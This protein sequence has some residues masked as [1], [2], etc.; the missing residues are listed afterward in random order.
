MRAAVAAAPPR[1]PAWR[2]TAT[3]SPSPPIERGEVRRL[4]A[5]RGTE[6]E[7]ALAGL[8]VE[9][10]GDG[11][12]GARLRHE[13]RPPAHSASR[14][15]RT[16]RRATRPSGSRS[17]GCVATGRRSGELLRAS[18]ASVFA[19]SAVSAGSLPAAI[20]A[21]ASSG[22]SGVDHSSAIQ[23][24]MR[25]A[26][27]GLGGR[28]VR[29]RRRP[30]R[31]PRA[32]ARRSTALTSPRRAAVARLTSSTD[33]PTAAWAGTRRGRRAGRR[34]RRSAREHGR[35]ELADRP[36]ARAPRSCGRASSAAGPCRTPAASRAPAR[37]VAAAGSRLGMQRAVG[38]GPL[39][40]DAQDHGLRAGARGRD[41]SGSR[42]RAP[43]ARSADFAVGQHR[44]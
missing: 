28:G 30:A 22:P 10:A 38:V 5:G 9:R 19:R 31:A 35:L 24:G 8:R 42:A 29:Q 44:Q 15:R 14:G 41:A 39:L 21:R 26:Q 23:S 40:E 16:A 36:A 7:H 27:R 11:H 12:R 17:A 4:A 1:G 32:A 37:A 3:T 13:Q 33:S 20:S 25:V 6:V 2:S 34:P 43:G 18:C